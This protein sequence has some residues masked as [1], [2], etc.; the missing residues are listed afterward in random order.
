MLKLCCVP[1]H[2]TKVQRNVVHSLVNELLERVG[3]GIACLQVL[4]QIS[5][6]FAQFAYKLRADLMSLP[7]THPAACACTVGT[8]HIG[9]NLA[10][11]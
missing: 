2:K 11:R 1:P 9:K 3:K 8:L 6:I 4:E 7:S 10:H 5:F